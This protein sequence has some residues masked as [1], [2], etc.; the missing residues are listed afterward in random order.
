MWTQKTQHLNNSH[1]PLNDCQEPELFRNQFPF[2]EIPRVLFD[3]QVIIPSPP[4]D[5]WITDTSFRDGQQARPPYKVAQII[6]LYE[7]LHK[8]GGPSGVVRQCE[9]FLYSD[10]DKKAIEGCLEK[11]FTYPEVT[12]WIRANKKDFSLVK[13]FELKETGI[14]TS[15]SDYHIFLKLK[16][17]RKKAMDDYL[18]IVKYALDEGIIPR[19]HFEDI[20]RADIYG[21]CLPFA[22]ELMKLSEQ[23]KIPV[24]I[25]LC[26]TMG[27]GVTLPGAILPR[28]VPKLAHAFKK[29]LGYPSHLLEWHGHNDFHKV[30]ANGSSAWLHGIS[31]LNCSLLGFGERTGNPPLEGA[32]IDYIGL[33]GNQNGIDTTIITEIADYFRK[34]IK[35]DIPSNFPFIGADFNT[36]RAGIHADGI[37]KNQEIYNIFDTEKILNRKI[38]V[39]ITDKSGMAGIARWI[40]ENV[41]SICN[42]TIGPISK[43]HPG[44]KKI[45]DWVMEQYTH[46]RTT[47]ISPEEL[48]AQAKHYIPSIFESDFILAKKAAEDIARKIAQKVALAP[49]L[50]SLDNEVVPAFLDRIIHLEPSIQLMT[51]TNLDGKRISQVHT[52]RGEKG[53]FR[54]LQ[55][56]SF[57]QREWFKY[58]KKNKEPWLSDL[59]FSE[60]T[61]KLIITAAVPLHMDNQLFALLDIDFKFDELVKLINKIPNDIV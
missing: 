41:E 37:L 34:E 46:G 10:K 8:L 19:C 9:F 49:E 18:D 56:K 2:H 44:V 7:L 59:F 61:H 50:H 48:V 13:D 29:E 30:L 17:S 3:D 22:Q 6:K 58:A 21:F 33:T 60:F 11:G 52:Q 32:I 35:A 45:Y 16:K 5:L 54:N 39:T 12:G 55:T 15:V 14:L 24:K 1:F 28:S 42:N 36:T 26:D 40:N 51:I 31:A 23:Y 4:D 25:R 53:L 57:D 43:R 38:R 47:G 27:F 20:T